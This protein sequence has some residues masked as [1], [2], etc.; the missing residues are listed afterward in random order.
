MLQ[1]AETGRRIDCVLLDM[2]MPGMTGVEVMQALGDD[3]QCPVIAVTGSLELEM[4]AK[5]K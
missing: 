5:M 2:I 3:L 4:V 1:N